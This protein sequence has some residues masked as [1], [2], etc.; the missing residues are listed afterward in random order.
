MTAACAYPAFFRGG[1]PGRVKDR[2]T[3]GDRQAGHFI[4][5]ARS[6]TGKA[7]PR[8]HTSVR[9]SSK[10]AATFE[11]IIHLEPPEVAYKK[12]AASVTLTGP[13]P[14]PRVR[15]FCRALPD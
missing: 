9:G 1:W 10:L 6:E 11:T 7:A 8:V 13:E 14:L 5:L 15:D 3:R 4:R 12:N 2:N